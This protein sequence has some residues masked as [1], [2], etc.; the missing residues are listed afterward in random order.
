[1]VAGVNF[2]QRNNVEAQ[3]AAP[4]NAPQNNVNGEENRPDLLD[5]AYKVL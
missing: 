4:I 1:M 2:L 5:L 3:P